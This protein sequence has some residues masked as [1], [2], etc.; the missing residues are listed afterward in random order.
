MR[1]LVTGATGF[2]GSNIVKTLLEEGNKIIATHRTSSSFEKCIMFKEKIHWINTDESNWKEQIKAISI[3]QLIH[4][5]W[6]GISAENRK[7]WELQLHNFL[8]SK[9]YFDLAHECEFKKVIAFGSQAEYGIY[10]FPV[11]ENTLPIPN[12][13]YAAVKLLTANYMRSK[14]NES[15]I[16][17]YWIR[18]FSVF[19]EGENHDW[20]IPKTILTLLK[21]DPI[22][23]TSCEQKYNYLYIMDFADQLLAVIHSRE[24]K[25]GIYN[26]CDSESISLKA[27]LIK[28]TDFLG[29]SQNL[30]KFG[31]LPYRYRQNMLIAGDN[32]KF[33]YNFSFDKDSLIG[34]TNGLQKTI[35]FHKNRSI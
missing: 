28:I 30:L 17:W 25:S 12:D 21:N 6:G 31:A 13:A 20:L 24:N 8:M 29:V 18:I 27:L 23:L 14:F 33:R 26:I 35:E 9:E 3:D 10:D 15:I 34:L 2:I 4:V 1:I 16:E 22:N 7:N 11:D 32:S 19:G 5:A